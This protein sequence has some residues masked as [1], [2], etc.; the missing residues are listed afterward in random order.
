MRTRWKSAVRACGLVAAWPGQMCSKA[1]GVAAAASWVQT[2]YTCSPHTCCQLSHH[3]PSGEQL[4]VSSVNHELGAVGECL[5][6]TPQS[7]L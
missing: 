2:K 7:C 4:V 6:P 3:S 1:E 5:A